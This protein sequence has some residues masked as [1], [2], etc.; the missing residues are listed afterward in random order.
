MEPEAG[1]EPATR[2]LQD[3]RSGR[4]ELPRLVGTLERTTGVAP[5]SPAWQ[6]GALLLS[7]ARWD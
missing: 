1:V 3:R 6:A 5:V 4:T 2:G 7:Y